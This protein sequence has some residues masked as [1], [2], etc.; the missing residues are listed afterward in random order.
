MYKIFQS[1]FTIYIATFLVS[2]GPKQL[3]I[4]EARNIQTNVVSVGEKVTVDAV[5]TALQDRLYLIDDVNHE[6]G[7]IKAS[8]ST[9]RKLAE[10]VVESDGSEMPLWVKITGIAIIITIIGLILFNGDESHDDE[11]ECNRSNHCHCNHHDHH[12]HYSSVDLHENR[13]YKYALNVSVVPRD[14]NKTQI[15]IIAQGET[16]SDGRVVSAGTIQDPRFYESIFNQ[17]E[18][19][20]FE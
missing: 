20:I 2:C 8:R 14:D 19:V 1:T 11:S 4:E 10:T 6:L 13:T 15:R 18:F 9:D 7:I 3:S 16:L 5:I 12:R 17:I